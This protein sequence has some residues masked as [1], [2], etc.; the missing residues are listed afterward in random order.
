MCDTFNHLL[1]PTISIDETDRILGESYNLTC[2]ASGI[3]N[4][5][6]TWKRDGN[7]LSEKHSTLTFT[8][9]R[10]SDGGRYTCIVNDTYLDNREVTLTGTHTDTIRYYVMLIMISSSSTNFSS[11][12]ERYI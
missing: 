6:F 1:A 9:L 3:S 8:P 2:S 4:P 12:N 7:V 10:L 11:V 5:K